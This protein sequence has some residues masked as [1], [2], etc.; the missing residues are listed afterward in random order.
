MSEQEPI[1]I[2]VPAQVAVPPATIPV[3]EWDDVRQRVVA[4]EGLGLV[5]LSDVDLSGAAAGHTL[6]R[7]EDGVWRA[8]SVAGKIKQVQ[9]RT[10]DDTSTAYPDIDDLYFWRGFEVQNP[11]AGRAIIT[12]IYG[13]TGAS[14]AVARD[15][16]THSVRVD[17]QLPFPASGSL[18]GGTRTLI[19]GNVTGLDP[20]RTY[21]LRGVL[22]VQLRGDGTGAGYT[23]PRITL[24]G[25][26]RDMP[27]RP[28][29]VA[30]VQPCYTMRHPGV[31][32]SG[33]SSVPVSAT[34][35]YSEG[36]ATWVG[37][38][39]LTIEVASNR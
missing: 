26:A 18:S 6:V 14:F 39:A 35:A 1:I 8:G 34:I 32:V 12:L 17:T 2:R 29:S 5:D 3:A 21:V 31:T 27:D 28:R 30:G 16:H 36:D 25:S 22:D 20:A 24:N 23:L 11:S 7:G 19:S 37:G 10:G 9:N 33:V 13:S 4:I 38:G 15:D